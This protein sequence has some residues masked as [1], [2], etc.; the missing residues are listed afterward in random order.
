MGLG[1][2]ETGQFKTKG[3]QGMPMFREEGRRSKT[4]RAGGWGTWV[5]QLVKHLT[6][7]FSLGYDL[8]VCGFEPHARLQADSVEPAWDFFSLSLCVP[9][10]LMHVC[11]LSKQIDIL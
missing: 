4:K 1:T 8:K 6:L 11:S 7:G 10:P 9:P 2:L 3:Y 5:A